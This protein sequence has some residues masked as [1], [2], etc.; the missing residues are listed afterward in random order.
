MITPLHILI[1]LHYHTKP[2]RYAEDDPAHARSA[3]VREYR[4]EMVAAQLLA[5]TADDY[6]AGPALAAWIDALISTPWPTASGIMTHHTAPETDDTHQPAT[7][8]AREDAVIER[9]TQIIADGCGCDGNC[10]ETLD[11]FCGCKRDAKAFLAL[12]SG[13]SSG[14]TVTAC[15]HD[16]QT[17]PETNGQEQRCML[18]GMHRE[19]PSMQAAT[20]PTAPEASGG[21]DAAL[22]SAVHNRIAAAGSGSAEITIAQ[23]RRLLELARRPSTSV[24]ATKALEDTQSLLASMLHEERP[25]DEIEEQMVANRRALRAALSPEVK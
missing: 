23:I 5:P 11:M 12:A 8:A 21:S 13:P 19:S 4:S 25:R 22:I 10:T 24:E 14:V 17:W 1:G 2:G 20:P 9:A 3:A 7:D 18:C 15:S 6:I 16:W